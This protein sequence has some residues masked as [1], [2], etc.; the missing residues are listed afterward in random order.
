MISDAKGDTRT[1]C[2]HYIELWLQDGIGVSLSLE[3]DE[4]LLPLVALLVD[5]PLLPSNERLLVDV[6]VDLDV[7]VV[8]QLQVVP[9]GV[10]N[11]R[12]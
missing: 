4:L 11:G 6:W 8:G 12:G 5:V 3:S 1:G 7:A 10:G 9:L 2:T